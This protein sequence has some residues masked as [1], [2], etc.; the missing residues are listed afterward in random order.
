MCVVSEAS[1]AQVPETASDAALRLAS[2]EVPPPIV[3]VARRLQGRGHAAVLVGGAVRDAL[4]G[5]PASDWDLATSATPEEVQ[6]LFRHTIPTGLEHGTVTVMVRRHGIGT[7]EPA[8]PVEVTTFRGEGAYLD[9]R[10]PTSVTFHRDLREDLARRDFTVNAFAWD[11]VDQVFSDPFDGLSD[12]RRGIIRAVG[13]PHARFQEDGLRTMRAVRLCATR[14]FCLE[15]ATQ[16]AIAPAL[17]VLDRVSRERVTVELRKLLE[18]AE[19]SIGLRPML[20]TGMWSHV[21]PEVPEA[22]V[23]AAI[24]AVDALPRVFELRLARLAWP[25]AHSGDEGRLRV[26]TVVDE[27]LRLSRAER[28]KIVALTSAAADAVAHAHEEVQIRRCAAALGREH[29]P[30]ALLV[31]GL[32][33]ERRAA[34]EQAIAGA[35]LTV[36][37]LAI[38]GRDLIAAGLV[39]PGRIVGRVLEGLLDRTLE[40]PALNEHETLA[41]LAPE[42]LAAL[43]D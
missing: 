3:A 37:E 30:G 19:P 34:I 38:R 35:P 13:D 21:L 40:Q 36:G 41:S 28:A 2:A 22:E 10:R 26:L 1:D 32:N 39:K 42:V 8:E 20:A 25:A 7:D 11:P 15:P 23:E 16:E 29:V 43:G 31:A 17:S 18:A 5:L 24:A 14:R 6:A 9:G 27:R 33:A 4:L 12:L